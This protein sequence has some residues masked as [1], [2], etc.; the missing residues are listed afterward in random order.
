MILVLYW[1]PGKDVFFP[2]EQ[3]P[4]HL[5]SECS[6][7]EI[8]LLLDLLLLRSEQNKSDILRS[9]SS[10]TDSFKSVWTNENGNSWSEL[11]QNRKNLTESYLD[12]EALCW[13]SIFV[14]YTLI[15]ITKKNYKLTYSDLNFTIISFIINQ[16]TL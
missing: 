16:I 9:R 11:Y 12:I 2:A 15:W 5:W 7:A 3:L 10:C 1:V 4:L 6:Y 8:D 13:S 14:D